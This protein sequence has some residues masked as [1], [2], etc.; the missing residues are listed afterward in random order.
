MNNE[1]VCI[2]GWKE[3]G[4]TECLFWRCSES[5]SRSREIGAGQA[6]SSLE[7]VDEEDT[8]SV[9]CQ[10][11]TCEK[12]MLRA[13]A[14]CESSLTDPRGNH[15]RGWKEHTSTSQPKKS[16]GLFTTAP[17][18]DSS[19]FPGANAVKTI[20][21]GVWWHKLPRTY[22]EGDLWVTSLV[23]VSWEQQKHSGLVWRSVHAGYLVTKI[24]LFWLR[25]FTFLRI[26][27][28]KSAGN[29]NKIKLIIYES[30]RKTLTLIT[31]NPKSTVLYMISDILRHL[32]S[33][34]FYVFFLLHILL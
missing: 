5:V 20:S 26:P 16:L 32:N 7:C 11:N 30:F 4:W 34:C 29:V 33:L 12:R 23:C 1:R 22:I 2:F 9:S 21:L 10:H 18:A 14:S 24:K 3:F 31:L 25:E 13:S 17:W 28:S 15:S 19:F 8:P 27:Y 6:W